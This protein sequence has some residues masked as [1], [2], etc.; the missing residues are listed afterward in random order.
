MGSQ[1]LSEDNVI[2][3]FVDYSEN[4]ADDQTFKGNPRLNELLNLG[5]SMFGFGRS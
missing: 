5:D 3:P 4:R 2:K 1:I